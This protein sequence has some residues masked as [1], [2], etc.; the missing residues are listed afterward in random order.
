MK[1]LVGLGNPGSK[2]ENTRHNAG[3]LVIDRL[4][5]RHAGAGAG[6]LP[7]AKFDSSIIEAPIGGERCLLMKPTTYMNRSG[8]AVAQAVGFY[9][10]NPQTD[11][12]V[13][14]DDV[15][16]PLGHL[17]IR[18][19]GSAGGHNGLAD[20]ERALSSDAYPR[21]RIGI[22]A[23]PALMDQADYVL[24]KFTPEQDAALKPALDQAADAAEC[25]VAHGTQAAMNKFNTPS[26][27]PKPRPA[28][29]VPPTEGPAAQAQGVKPPAIKPQTP[30][31]TTN[32]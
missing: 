5:R 19:S 2:Y 8:Q 3:Y 1:L 11:V 25:F 21:L 27:P 24:G 30:D 28:R 4:A 15:A 14:V 20:I 23:K 13:I 12:L 22:D 9:K 18:P 26:S 10:V 7:K 31:T 29:P 32:L 6:A 16:L 17:R